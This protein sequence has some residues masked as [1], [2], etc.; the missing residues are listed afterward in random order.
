MYPLLFQS[1]RYWPVFF[2]IAV[3][4]S[5]FGPAPMGIAM[6]LAVVFLLGQEHSRA[7]FQDCWKLTCRSPFG[8]AILALFA[9]WL[10][11]SVDSLNFVKSIGTWIRIL[12]YLGIAF[13]AFRMF[14]NHAECAARYKKAALISSAIVLAYIAL[15]L[16]GWSFLFTPI[17]MLKGHE[18]SAHNYFKA[19]GSTAVVVL[20]FLI[21]AGWTLGGRWRYLASLNAVLTM[22]LVYGGGWELSLSGIAGA[23]GAMCAILF[24]LAVG[25]VKRP[26][27][28]VLWLAAALVSIAIAW[29]VVSIL[30]RPPYIDSTP[31]QVPFVDSHRELIWSF[32][33]EAQKAVPFFGYGPNAVNYLP[34]AKTII[35]SMNQ[36]YVP[37]HPHNWMV[38]TL[39]ET[40]WVGF[41]TLLTCIALHFRAAVR[42]IYIDKAAALTVV[43]CS[44][45]FWVS[46]LVNF[47]FWTSW[48]QVAYLL[49]LVAP[50]AEIQRRN[51]S[52]A[53]Q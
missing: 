36:E 23:I 25:S 27:G 49:A 24:C 37:S 18:L 11:S 35:Q 51:T 40:G 8:L 19:H 30:P 48:W 53:K 38:E 39:A 28:Y 3:S 2:A 47:S 1:G 43:A 50:L 14:E 29:Y 52:S 6:L 46:G 9:C 7:F 21:W 20:P 41:L 10:I 42:A 5:A 17:E 16:L 45:A 13:L 4:A 22:V 15:V 32:V 12:F 26:V 44:G 33:L 31:D 34:G